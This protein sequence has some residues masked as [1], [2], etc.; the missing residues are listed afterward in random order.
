[1]KVLVTGGA[2]FIGSHVVDAY[3]DAGFDVAVVDNLSSGRR[4]YLNPRARFYEMDIR[5]SDLSG[6]FEKE[7]PE[8]VNHHAAQPSV[9]ASVADP[10]HDAD[11]N[12][13]GTLNLLALGKEFGARKFI[14][15]STGGAIYGNPEYIP[16]DEEHPTRPLSPYGI[17]KMVGEYYVRFYGSMG[18]AGAILRY[19]NVYGPRQD[20]HGEAGVVAIFSNAML[21]GNPPAIYGDGTQTRD[22]VYVEDVARAN[23]LATRS[24]V[25]D[26]ANIATGVET[27]VNDTFR[28]IAEFTEFRDEPDYAPARAGEVYRIALDITH[29]KTWLGWTPRTTLVQGL[30]QTVAWFRRAGRQ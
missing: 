20:P 3:V 11:V 2:G 6:V 26:T 29:A 10:G 17:G 1:M 12:I 13:M 4:D 15:A 30:E 7:R 28:H 27:T 14:F 16:A 19:A 24:E 5:D 22:F 9:T 25:S 8:V 21:A 23:L 18:I